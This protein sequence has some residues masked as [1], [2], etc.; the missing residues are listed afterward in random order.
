MVDPSGA[1]DGLTLGRAALTRGAWGVAREYFELELRDHGTP[2]PPEGA[3]VL[4]G[5][6]WAAWWLDDGDAC[7]DA[8]ER[9][10]R[11]YRD[12]GDARG[13]ARM[14]LWLSDD[15]VEFRGATAVAG[16]WRARAARLLDELEP[17][18]EHGWLS[19]FEAHEALGREEPT[20]A[21][22]LAERVRE[23]GRRQ[24]QVDLEVF[25]LATE[26]VALVALGDLV[27]GLRALDEAA[28]AALAGEYDHLVAAA[29]TCC[30]VM[31]TCEQV[32]DYD[33]AAQWCRQI[34]EFARR[35]D[36]G[37]LRGVCR[38]HYGVVQ[39]WRGDWDVAE[40]ELL[41]AVDGPAATRPAWR[42]DAVVRLAHLRRR[43]GRWAEAEHLFDE[44][45]DH[46]LALPG[47]AAVDLAQ[48]NAEH[49]R[50]LLERAL[51]RCRPEHRA[52]R[53]DALELLVRTHI[54]R[55]D[56]P[57]ATA[58]LEELR[59]VAADVPTDAMV[60][61]LQIAEGMIAAAVG[62]QQRAC[63]HLEDAVE[64]LARCGARV[65]AAQARLH[66]GRSL[67]A[68]GRTD[69]AQREARLALAGLHGTHAQVE[70]ADALALADRLATQRDGGSAERSASILTRR[71]VEVL[72]LVA[73]GMSDRSIAERLV[74]SPHT[75]HRHVA[76]IYGR[77]G[78]S[79]RSAAV[80]QA[81]RLG[82]L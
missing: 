70:R 45:A 51:R 80:A 32:R 55:D 10:Y 71:Q 37:F 82:L 81:T 28:A 40:R 75:V 46:P 79:S 35:L 5:L 6:S 29:W 76:N 30:L 8:R 31:A 66:L 42:A 9:A 25:G 3:E 15:H 22:K 59:L 39:V 7:L 1:D 43:Q 67:A 63:H 26:G 4:E 60:A 23:I 69:A 41:A 78:C 36:A 48:G 52:A 20:E 14:A 34:E 12:D 64:R 38:A 62:D 44:V 77:L 58:A 18:P 27:A 61:A 53:A 50:D 68:L 16:G 65:E 21:H 72:R 24:A 13:A 73:D 11:A 2:T 74:V 49:A 33:R 19:L 56:V 54:A 17:A 47:R 57:A